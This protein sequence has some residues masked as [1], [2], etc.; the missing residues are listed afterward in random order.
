LIDSFNN[1]KLGVL[2]LK[3]DVIKSK[4]PMN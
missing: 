1:D 3:R 2:V 4:A